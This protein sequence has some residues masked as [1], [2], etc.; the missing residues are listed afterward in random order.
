[1]INL[2]QA[3]VKWVDSSEGASILVEMMN[4]QLRLFVSQRMP[5]MIKEALV[6]LMVSLVAHVANQRLLYS[7][8]VKLSHSETFKKDKAPNHHQL[9]VSRSM[10]ATSA[11]SLQTLLRSSKEPH[12]NVHLLTILTGI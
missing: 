10:S 7:K 1:M 4:L 8:V 12:H 3:H 6:P 2:A 11:G 5:T 9:S